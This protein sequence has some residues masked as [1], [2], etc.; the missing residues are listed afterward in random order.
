MDDYGKIVY[1]GVEKTGSR[2]ISQFLSNHL[3][4]Q[5]LEFSKHGR[6]K[7][8]YRKDAIYFIS[9]RNP[10]NQYL[11]LFQF[12]CNGKGGV[13]QKLKALGYGNLY[14]NN[15]ESFDQWLNLMLS[16]EVTKLIKG[17]YSKVNID[18]IGLQTFRFLVLSFQY[19]L[20]ILSNI[21]D[22]AEL[23]RLYDE[24]KIHRYVL[25]NENLN[26][27]LMMMV[28]DCLKPYIKD[29]ASAKNYLLSAERINVSTPLGLDT[30]ALTAKAC[31]LLRAKERFLF[32]RFYP[33][34]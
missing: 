24:K 13:F 32:E 6:I 21:N 25:R 12:G 26:H 9:V 5:L 33:A 8:N 7:D 19:P 22:Y 23:N 4:L 11:S 14:Q 34:F 20:R 27:D 2:F 17:G 30:N 31:K 15:I 18:L 28:D 29:I 1:L 3:N 10:L 16:P